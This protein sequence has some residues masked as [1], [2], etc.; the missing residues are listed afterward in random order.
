M[1]FGSSLNGHLYLSK[2]KYPEQNSPQVLLSSL[3]GRT[4]GVDLNVLLH[5][6]MF[7]S[8]T[9]PEFAD[10]SDIVQL[11]NGDVAKYLNKWYGQHNFVEL[12]IALVFVMDGLEDDDKERNV[13]TGR[14]RRYLTEMEIRHMRRS[15]KKMNSNT[16]TETDLRDMFRKMRQSVRLSTRMIFEA[17]EWCR[18]HD[19]VTVMFAAAQADPQLVR[20]EI[21]GVTEGTISVDTDIFGHGSTCFVKGL[22]TL[23]KS[24]KACILCPETYHASSFRAAF[25]RD[26]SDRPRRIARFACRLRSDYSTTG[27]YCSHINRIHSIEHVTLC[28]LNF[29]TTSLMLR[30]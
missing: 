17:V 25:G 12:G 27:M 23:R 6:A 8:Y 29:L 20:L 19:G 18:C 22:C 16:D 15:Y 11:Q 30:A 24:T 13:R 26:V 10:D 2:R 21:D 4:L 7:S 28:S 14:G 5:A 3:R 1:G 9:K